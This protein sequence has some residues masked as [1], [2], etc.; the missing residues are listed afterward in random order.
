M[1]DKKPIKKSGIIKMR[2]AG[3]KKYITKIQV[4]E[5]ADIH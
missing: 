4:L 2:E 3:G 1:S 5:I